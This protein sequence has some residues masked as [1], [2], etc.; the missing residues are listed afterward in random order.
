MTSNVPGSDF[1]MTD[2]PDFTETEL[3]AM[4]TAVS[5]RY[6]KSVDIDIELADAELRLDPDSTT[7]TTCPAAFW[8]ERGANFVIVKLGET[9]FRSQFY[10]SAREQYGTGRDTYN[11]IGECVMVLLQVQA[12]HE[13][14]KNL[15]LNK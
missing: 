11:D 7:L 5:E 10:Y 14:D 3:W 2:I 15:G 13:R 8:S 4:R 6:G 9:K 1:K 12:D